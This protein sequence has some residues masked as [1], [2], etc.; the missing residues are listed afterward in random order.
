MPYSSWHLPDAE[1][2]LDKLSNNAI[3]LL[4]Q[5]LTVGSENSA[6]NETAFKEIYNGNLN[7]FLKSE[8]LASESH[9]PLL[10]QALAIHNAA[11]NMLGGREEIAEIL[12][13]G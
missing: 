6:H 12:T 10:V 4:D 8:N 1:G 2:R 11:F 9:S 5:Y 7:A 13:A 3:S